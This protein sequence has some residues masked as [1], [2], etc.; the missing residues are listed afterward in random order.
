V[1]QPGLASGFT[2]SDDRLSVTVAL[3]PGLKFSDGTPLDADAAVW[4]MKRALDPA[5]ACPCASL[6]TMVKDIAADGPDKVV[7]ALKAPYP[8]L[9]PAFINTAMNWMASPT[10]FQQMGAADFGQKPIGAGPF[11]VVSNVASQRLE[12]E[13]NP[14][15]WDPQLP[16]LD[17]LVFQAAG[18]DESAYAA[19][20]SGTAA[21]ITGLTSIAL[22]AQA[23]TQFDVIS[24]PPIGTW[25]LQFNTLAPPLDDVRARQALI[26]ATDIASL[27]Q[28]VTKGL[29]KLSQSPGG[30][31]GLFHDDTVP[32]TLGFD[33]AKAT[34]LVKQIGGL[35]VTLLAGIPGQGLTLTT[36]EA[37]QSMWEKAGIEVELAQAPVATT[38]ENYKTGNWSVNL[39][40][41]GAIDP[42]L[43]LGVDYYFHTDGPSSG[44]AD[45]QLDALLD[46][47][48]VAADPG[49]RGGIYSQAY[50]RIND[51]AYA[52][53]LYQYN[54][55]YVARKTVVGLDQNAK[56][57]SWEQVSVST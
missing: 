12:L 50:E 56:W 3:R 46:Q 21:A 16:Y 35:K 38:L 42:A 22:L 24:I 23:K 51:Q 33:L 43:R 26:Q 6:F 29:Y 37:I 30:D 54:L 8:P 28:F 11:T 1:I 19:V 34:D 25:H 2:V 14:T 36:A 10:A 48:R 44:V 53:F 9:I 20:Q 45:P 4:N 13:R 39:G 57:A 5:S 47:A 15:Y 55:F 7:L 41:S 31:G 32:G 52:A 40:F 49:A 27:S 17:K 18:S